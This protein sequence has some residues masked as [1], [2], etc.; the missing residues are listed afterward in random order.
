MNKLFESYYKLGFVKCLFLVFCIFLLLFSRFYNL[1]RNFKFNRDESSDLV[2]MHQ[3]WVDKKISLIGPISED[4]NLVYSSFSYYL[5]MPFAVLFNFSAV[6]PTIGNSFWSVIT[7]LLMIYFLYKKFGKIELLDYLLILIW[8]PMLIISR[9]AW[10]PNL[11]PLVM[12]VG[13]LLI[14]T[15]K[16]WGNLIG[17]LLLGLSGHMHY[18]ALISSG[19]LG[20]FKSNKIF[21]LFGFLIPIGIFVAFD[22]THLPGLFITRA[23]LF[24]QGQLGFNLSAIVVGIKY[25]FGSWITFL[26]IFLL[27]INDIKYKRYISIYWF[28][29][30][31][32]FMAV[33]FLKKPEAH[34]FIAAIIPFWMW[35][36]VNRN[37]KDNIL[38][39]III[40]L[41]I[42][43]SLNSSYNLIFGK[44]P[45]DSSYSAQQISDEIANN[46]INNNLLNPNLTVLQSS[47]INSFGVKYRDLLLVNNVNIKSKDSFETSDNLFVI[48]QNSN[49][50]E[51]RKDPSVQIS[52]FKNGPVTLQKLILG[53]NWWVFRFDKY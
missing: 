4:G 52:Y 46:I 23:F 34:Y 31:S 3:Y 16:W 7:A 37:I 42:F 49:I 25:L 6:S 40:L 35:L 38:R 17:G 20:F 26:F 44:L 27:M 2:K 29:I 36:N 28:S 5:E 8:Y 11:I 12:I 10:N 9:W 48:T 50:D 21:F 32:L 14:E 45:D 1:E 13:V 30:I 47:D 53:T 39:N 43:F 24:K 19:I 18:L 15:K 41:L 33:C 51:L 22:L